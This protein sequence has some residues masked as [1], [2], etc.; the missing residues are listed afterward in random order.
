MWTDKAT[1]EL[2]IDTTPPYVR[3][4]IGTAYKSINLK[5]SFKS[6][7]SATSVWGGICLKYIT[8]LVILPKGGRTN[9][10]KYIK[11]IHDEGFNLYQRIIDEYGDAIWMQDGAPYH[12]SKLTTAYLKALHMQAMTWPP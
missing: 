2:G 11:V 7:R 6:G 3:R 5:P 10:A 12:T 8:N 1:M 9:S 4:K